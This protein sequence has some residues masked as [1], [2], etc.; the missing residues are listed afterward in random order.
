MIDVTAAAGPED[1]DHIGTGCLA[2]RLL[3]EVRVVGAPFH[4]ADGVEMQREVAEDSERLPS[5]IANAQQ[6]DLGIDRS[7]RANDFRVVVALPR[8]HAAVAHH[9]TAVE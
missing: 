3:D 7:R 9:R 2:Q 6:G 5:L 8:L 1:R 4:S